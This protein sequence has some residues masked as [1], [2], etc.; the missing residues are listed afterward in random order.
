M[1]NT[2]KLKTG[3]EAARAVAFF[4]DTIP[5]EYGEVVSLSGEQELYELLDIDPSYKVNHNGLFDPN[6]RIFLFKSKTKDG[7]GVFGR[8]TQDFGNIP[9]VTDV[10]SF[11]EVMAR[12]NKTVKTENKPDRFLDT[13]VDIYIAKREVIRIECADDF[14]AL[15]GASKWDMFYNLFQWAKYND[16]FFIGK[17]DGKYIVQPS[18]FHIID[19]HRVDY[20][21]VSVSYAI[22][23]QINIYKLRDNDKK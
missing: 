20:K 1:E 21:E 7:K 3:E 18:P 13:L 17:E 15:F 6:K 12:M 9:V 4:A 2:K 11:E 16:S 14:K 5:F 8:A 19:G 22:E 10:I 23:R